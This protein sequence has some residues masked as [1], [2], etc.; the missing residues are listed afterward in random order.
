MSSYIKSLPDPLPTGRQLVQAIKTSGLIG[1]PYS[2]LDCQAAVEKALSLVGVVVNYRGSNHMWREL[3]HDRMTYDECIRKYGCI[4]P[5]AFCFSLYHDGSEIAKGYRDTMGAA[6]HVG[7]CLG[8][9]NTI[10]HSTSGGVQY[11]TFGAAGTNRIAL[12]NL[13]RY[14]TDQEGG[15][16]GEGETFAAGTRQALQS[17]LNDLKKA[18]T[19]LEGVLN[20]TH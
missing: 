10:F 19:I 13:L 7:I 6:K 15:A 8:D 14:E 9:G 3:V 2:K 5:G 18:T 11:G 17:L 4:P 1:T 12:C 20:E 16:E